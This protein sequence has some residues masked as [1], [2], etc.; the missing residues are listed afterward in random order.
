[1]VHISTFQSATTPTYISMFV[2]GGGLA[3]GLVILFGLTFYVMR[4]H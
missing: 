3:L 4:P 2:V 1:M